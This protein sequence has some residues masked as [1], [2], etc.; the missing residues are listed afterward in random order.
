MAGAPLSV[1]SLKGAP[2]EVSLALSLECT[3]LQGPPLLLRGPQRPSALPNGPSRA[4]KCLRDPQGPPGALKCLRGPQ[5]PSSAPGAPRGPH[6]PSTRG[7]PRGPSREGPEGTLGR[8]PQ[9]RSHRE[10]PQGY[11]REGPPEAP[12]EG[13]QRP[14]GRGPKGGPPSLKP[15]WWGGP[16]GAP[17]VTVGFWLNPISGPQSSSNFTEDGEAHE[18]PQAKLQ[19]VRLLQPPTLAAAAAAAAVVAVVAAVAAF[20]RRVLFSV[21]FTLLLQQIFWRAPC[22]SCC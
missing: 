16:L 18:A 14:P 20:L 12:R 4:L 17:G 7:A 8:G 21:C 5:G 10:G 19:G 1:A 15:L 11:P 6:R 9:G 3:L 2:L 22:S 13:P